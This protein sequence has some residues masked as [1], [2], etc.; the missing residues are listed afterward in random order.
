M[1]IALNAAGRIARQPRSSMLEVI[2]QDYITTARAKGQTEGN[3]IYVHALRNAL[4][5]VVTTIGALLGV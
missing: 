4:I 3:V 1:L 2:R 5:P